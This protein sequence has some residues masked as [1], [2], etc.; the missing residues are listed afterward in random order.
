M[1]HAQP[2]QRSLELAFGVA[3]IGAGA[4]AE[5]AQAV[6]F[7]GAAEMLEV[8]PWGFG[9]NEAARNVAARGVIGH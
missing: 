6:G 1:G 3:L 8:I 7:E 9:A 4:R 5:V 2:A